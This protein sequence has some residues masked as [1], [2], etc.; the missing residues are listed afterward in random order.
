MLIRPV[1][2]EDWEAIC[3]IEAEAFS[4]KE[5]ATPEDLA[6]RIRDL[7][8][9]FL[10]AVIEEQVAGFIVAAQAHQRHLTDNLFHETPRLAEAGGFLL[11]TSLAVGKLFRGKGVG[12]ALITAFKTL[13]NSQKLLG[14]S[15]TCHE[16]LI[17]YYEANGFQNEGLS[18]S[19]HGGSQWFN[20]VWE[21]PEESKRTIV[22]NR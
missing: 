22:T 15:L 7:S 12:T 1:R 18:T 20:L 6:A 8:S 11:V 2:Q 21:R 5:A 19:K 9:T 3:Q 17:A 4:A 13:A 14:I 16:T 10:V